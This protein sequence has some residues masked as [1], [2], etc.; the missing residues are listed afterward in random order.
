MTRSEKDDI[1][2]RV[3]HSE[4]FSNKD[5]LK[6]LMLYLY[7]KSELNTPVHEIDIAIDIFNRGDDFI[8]SDD[9]IVRVNIHKLRL[10]LERYTMEEGR[11][12]AVI[13]VIPKGC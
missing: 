11:K 10:A 5:V 2:N 9:T 8:A 7:E 3:I 1:I 6:R 4:L 12:E 13:P